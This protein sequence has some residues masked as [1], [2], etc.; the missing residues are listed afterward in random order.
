MAAR[1]VL[2]DAF[3]RVASTFVVTV[4]TLATT[5]GLNIQDYLVLDN[6]KAWGFAGV[7]AAL[8]VVKT[9]VAAFI[10]RRNGQAA[11]ASLAPSVVLEPTGGRVA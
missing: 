1:P 11:S 2:T 9:I 6:W 8:T 10:A 4:L 5:N 7:A 3:E